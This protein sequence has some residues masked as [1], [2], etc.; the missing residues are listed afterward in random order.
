MC[1]QKTISKLSTDLA[2]EEVERVIARNRSSR[3]AGSSSSSSSC[4]LQDTRH[5]L[6][7]DSLTSLSTVVKGRARAASL[8]GVARKELPYICL[9]RLFSCCGWCPTEKNSGGPRSRD[10]DLEPPPRKPDS[11][12]VAASEGVEDKKKRRHQD[13]IVVDAGPGVTLPPSRCDVFGFDGTHQAVQARI[14]REPTGPE[15]AAPAVARYSI[16]PRP[17]Q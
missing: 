11:W 6:G 2:L 1:K 3:T 17:H 8:N 7:D 5:L 16:D 10:L 15:V 13:L 4:G 12:F 9:G 14:R